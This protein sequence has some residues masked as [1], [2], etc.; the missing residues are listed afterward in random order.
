MRHHEEQCTELNR[1]LNDLI[2]FIY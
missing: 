2:W 1:L